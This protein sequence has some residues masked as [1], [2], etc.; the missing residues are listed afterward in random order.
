[1]VNTHLLP[2]L[3]SDRIPYK[4][5]GNVFSNNKSKILFINFDFYDKYLPHIL[6]NPPIHPAID[7]D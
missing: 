5:W 7:Q 4:I 3:K 2:M 1:M 6:S